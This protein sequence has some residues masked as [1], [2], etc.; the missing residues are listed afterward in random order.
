MLRSNDADEDG[1]D[2]FYQQLQT[3]LDEGIG[4]SNE[5]REKIMAET[6]VVR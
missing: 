6:D 4:I 1:T 3:S 5:G 2:T